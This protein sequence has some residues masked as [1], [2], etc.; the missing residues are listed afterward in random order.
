MAVLSLV[1]YFQHYQPDNKK[2]MRYITLAD[3]KTHIGVTG[4]STDAFLTM[5]IKHAEARLDTLLSVSRLDIH[6]VDDERHDAVG[7]DRLY[8]HD[9]HA[10]EIGEI[11]DNETVYTQDDEYDVSNYVLR[12]DGSLVQGPRNAHVDYA[13]GWNAAGIVKLTV[14]DYSLITSTMTIAIEPG[15]AGGATTLTEGTEWTAATSNNVT[16]ASIAAAIN[17][18]VL[19][20]GED[21]ATGTRA[22]ALENVVYIADETPDRITSEI[23]LSALLGLS[24]VSGGGTVGVAATILALDGKDFPQDLLDAL[25]LM[26]GSSFNNRKSQGIKSYKIGSKSVTYSNGELMKEIK[27]IVRAH[28]RAAIDVV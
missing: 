21:T 5:E 4:A 10:V 7:V 27:S 1:G 2:H 17:D 11:L 26:V 25:V 12:L 6:K 18:S 28:M 24:M 15:G 19:H 20:T 8:L 3:L 9:L 16:A 23:T 14:S 13:A 22:F